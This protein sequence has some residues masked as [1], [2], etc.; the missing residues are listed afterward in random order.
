MTFLK[1]EA[2]LLQKFLQLLTDK[3]DFSDITDKRVVE[4]AMLAHPLVDD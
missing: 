3:K 4:A 1:F 2:T